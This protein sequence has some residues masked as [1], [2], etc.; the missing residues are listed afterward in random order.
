MRYWVLCLSHHF[1]RML[2]NNC[3]PQKQK[4]V[5]DQNRILN[6]RL[7]QVDLFR[8]LSDR[9][10]KSE[11]R[12]KWVSSANFTKC[13]HRLDWFLYRR[14]NSLYLIVRVHLCR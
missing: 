13:H 5:L 8:L 11:I 1:R 10:V 4:L 12:R 6:I 7:S 14:S 9:H 2:I 3:F